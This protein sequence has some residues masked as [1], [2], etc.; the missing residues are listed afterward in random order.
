MLSNHIK[1]DIFLAFQTGGCLLLHESS[2][3]A[4]AG[5]SALLSFS[6]LLSIAIIMSPEMNGWSLK[7]SLIVF[8]FYILNFNSNEASGRS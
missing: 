1:P 6:N 7:T 2:A 3:K 5:F 4:P 8:T